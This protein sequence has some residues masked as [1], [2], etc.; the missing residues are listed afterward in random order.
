MHSLTIRDAKVFLQYIAIGLRQPVFVWGQPGAA[1]S[2]GIAQLAI[3]N[4]ALNVD[5]RLSQYDSVDVRG[6]PSP[7]AA[8]KTTVWYA[9]STLPFV[10]N[11]FPTDRMIILFLDEL[12]SATPSVAAVAYQL[13]NDR[14]V[15][16]HVLMDNVVVIAAGNRDSDRGVTNRMPTPLANRFTHIEVVPDAE[17]WCEDY[18]VPKGL[19]PV[20]IAFLMFRKSLIST[21]DPA[22]AD[23]AFATPRTWAKAL[24]YYDTPMPTAIKQAAMAGAVGDGPAAE[25][26]GFVDVW[27]RVP[28]INEIL[29]TPKTF[30]VSDEMSMQYAVAMTLSGAMTMKTTPAINLY[31][32][33]MPPDYLVM[34]WH[35]ALKRDEKLLGTT[36]F[37]T[38]ADKLKKVF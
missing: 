25:F 32:L 36:E 31:L 10:G 38:V 7:D 33:R 24:R 28:D 34:A 12:N 8:T 18:A 13:I 19:P 20:G 21:F 6:I 29:K 5:V 15:G 4:D 23:K 11:D 16:E 37:L 17:V 26:W 1:K 35:L 27:S 14:R 22:R 9:P 3:D 30:P 2:E